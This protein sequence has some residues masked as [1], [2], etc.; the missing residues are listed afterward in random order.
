M[1]QHRLHEGT[2]SLLFGDGPGLGT[3]LVT[4]PRVHA[5]GFTGSRTGGLALV[6]AAA[7]R[8]RPIPVYAEMSS[9]NPVLVLPAVLAERGAALGTALVGSMTIGVG[10]LCTSPGLVFVA[11]GDGFA[12]FLAAATEAV[13]ASPAA[14][15]LTAGIHA[16]FNAGLERLRDAGG[17]TLAVRGDGDDTI[18]AAGRAGLFVT[19]AA[20]FLAN[21]ALHEEVFGAASLIVRVADDGQLVQIVERLDGQL[22]A[23]VHAAAGDHEQA[24]RLLP[25]LELVAGRIVF[26]GWPT[27]VEVG[28]AVV[29]GGPFPATSD[30][31]MTS[32]GTLAIE[33]FLRPVSYQD[34]P[35]E[36]LPPALADAN[37]HGL[38]RL[39]DGRPGRG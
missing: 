9:V 8:P 10:Q 25:L 13:R 4:H 19:D 29:H 23:T 15:M 18:A 12:E 2:F 6:A 16:A 31:R 27:G 24:C 32:V 14:P 38:W 34:V 37:P 3:D 5:V 35:A 33:R 7:A 36:L 17:V 11:D 30:P 28:H 22:T 26:N 20:T 39:V 21:P 1:R